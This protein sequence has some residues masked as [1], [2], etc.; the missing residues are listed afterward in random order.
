[1]QQFIYVLKPVRIEML[2]AGP[3]DEEAQVVGAH[4]DFLTEK[5]N[6]DVVLLAGRTQTADD[7]TFGIVILQAADQQSAIDLMQSDPAVREG[8]MTAKL[9]P[10][11]IAVASGAILQ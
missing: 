10:Y 3:T 9:Y 8:V 4:V 1:M 6:H 11:A 5:S 7:E 2:Q